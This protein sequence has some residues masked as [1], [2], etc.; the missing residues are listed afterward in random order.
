M[1]QNLA[2][3]RRRAAEQTL[4]LPF[5]VPPQEWFTLQKAGD[6]LGLAESTAEKLYDRGDLTGHSHNAGKGL[7]DHKRVLR[8]SLIA[9]AVRTADYTDE[10]LGDSLIAACHHLPASTKERLAVSCLV[11]MP[12]EALLRVISAAQH[13]LRQGQLAG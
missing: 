13:L 11:G 6:V 8:V 10:S 3:L 2:S 5:R 1:A 7:R 9:Y 4:A 12:P